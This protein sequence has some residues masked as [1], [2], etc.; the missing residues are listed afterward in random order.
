MLHS[1]TILPEH[2]HYYRLFC[3]KTKEPYTISFQPGVNILS[4]PNGHGKS[5]LLAMIMDRITTPEHKEHVQMSAE[6]GSRFF[7]FPV[8]Q[9][10]PKAMVHNSKPS[11]DGH[12]NE[13]AFWMSRINLSH[14]QSTRELIDDI[15]TISK[16]LTS[17]T[18]LIDEPELALDALGIEMLMKFL[19]TYATSTDIQF[20]VVTHHPFLLLDKR[21]HQ[22]EM[23]PQSGYLENVKRVTM[24]A[25][26]GQCSADS[27]DAPTGKKKS[28]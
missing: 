8:S 12:I 25:L 23:D 27:S 18:L 22:I 10:S 26:A 4:S 3:S 14:G 19:A 13:L 15:K 1:A 21:F 7:H 20:I 17:L 6:K 28:A 2:P 11:G 5:S 24:N 16:D 9:M